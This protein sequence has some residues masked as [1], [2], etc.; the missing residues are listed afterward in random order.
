MRVFGGTLAA[1]CVYGGVSWW[2]RTGAEIRAARA[3]LKW[4]TF[5]WGTKIDAQLLMHGNLSFD[6]YEARQRE[7]EKKVAL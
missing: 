3:A 6:E 4:Q 5:D 7:R 2:L 1:L